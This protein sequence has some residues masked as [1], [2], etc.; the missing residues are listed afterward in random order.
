MKIKEFIEDLNQQEVD[1]FWSSVDSAPQSAI[2][3]N[4]KYNLQREDKIF[5]FKWFVTE[6][7]KTKNIVVDFIS[8]YENRY[9]FASSFGFTIHE[10]LVFDNPEFETFEKFYQKEV[11]NKELF[12][13]F[14]NY[15]HEL[16]VSVNAEP[17][18]VRTAI[19]QDRDAMILMG[20]RPVVIF[21]NKGKNSL[22]FLLD[23]SFNL[24]RIENKIRYEFKGGDNK[25]LVEVFYEKWDDIPKELIE[26]N[27]QQ[28]LL[29]YNQI[30]DKKISQWNAEAQTTNSTL[31]YLFFKNENVQKLIQE[32][33]NFTMEYFDIDGI[34]KYK[35]LITVP[36]DKN[37]EATKIFN[38]T[39]TKIKYLAEIFSEKLN[40]KLVNNYREKINKMSGQGNTF[41]NYKDYILE[42]FIPSNLNNY[43]KD[44]FIKIA[45][46][47]WGGVPYLHYQLDVN[48]KDENNFF[49]KDRDYLLELNDFRLDVDEHFPKDWDSL[50]KQTFNN[51]ELL[52][53]GFIEYLSNH[54]GNVNLSASDKIIQ[55]IKHPLNQILFGCPGSGKTYSTKKLA[56]EI[57]EGKKLGDSKEERAEILDKYEDYYNSKQIR[58]TTFHQ[59]LSY[60]DFIEGIKP[61]TVNKQIIYE[62]ENGIFNN[63]SQKAQDN[64]LNFQTVNTDELPF[65]ESF[66]KL[67][68]EWEEDNNIKFPLKTKDNDFTITGFNE[69]NLSFK[70]AS[71]GTSHTLS[72]NTLKELYYGKRAFAENGVGIYYPSIIKHLK[73]FK[74]NSVNEKKLE[75]FVLIIDEINRGNVSKIF[76][77]LITLIEDNKRLGEDEYIEITLPYSGDSFGVP[78]NLYIVGTMNTADRSVEALDTALRRRFS[79][80]EMKSDP[81]VIRSAND[82][83]G[84]IA[85]NPDINLIDLL[86]KI[87]ERIE[88]LLDKDHQ[89][90]HSYFIGINT[91]EELKMTFKNK[92]I[93][94]LEE[95]FYGDF[96]KIGLV[97]GDKFVTTKTVNEN[98]NVLSTFK[99]YEDVDFL[100][101]KKIYIFKDMKEIKAEDFVSIYQKINVTNAESEEA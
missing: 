58:F 73:S 19:T 33:K 93:P 80:T 25:I 20:Q 13:D 100:T 4:W 42:G 2:D 54:S 39:R 94:L 30:K 65:E 69:K 90:G 10:D 26:H 48:F 7:G 96:G 74:G 27:K 24:E 23:K 98:K 37:S 38:D 11:Y 82:N 75:N 44:I 47:F 51:F 36:Y 64:W 63:I 97:L 81:E 88:L 52:L 85:E 49:N 78:P 40:L 59:S 15:A 14:I 43:G 68:D 95:Y 32:N 99:G 8:N 53:N 1:Q 55:P 45:F 61:Q 101:D 9:L 41:H 62:V 67:R 22:N 91:L 18:K 28:S 6:L 5:P 31:K 86:I 92:V 57:I 76:G 72:F 66:A 12:Q 46:G 87:N 77:E 79:F 35:D 71:G 50:I 16:L 89:I 29:Q 70:K 3:R 60:E 17:Y 21:S 83:K 56:V 34:L 84:N